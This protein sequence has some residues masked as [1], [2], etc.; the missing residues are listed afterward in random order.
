M[1][2]STFVGKLDWRTRQPSARLIFAICTIHSS[3]QA[4][5]LGTRHYLRRHRGVGKTFM[6][7]FY[8]PRYGCV[9]LEGFWNV[10]WRGF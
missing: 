6:A 3:S 2:A 7:G 9:F 8:V 10:A 4:L 1:N 5:F